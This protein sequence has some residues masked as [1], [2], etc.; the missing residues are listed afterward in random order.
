MKGKVFKGVAVALVLIL[1]ATVPAAA[2]SGRPVVITSETDQQLLQVILQ[3][4]ITTFVPILAGLTSTWVARQIQRVRMQMTVDQI[5]FA[6][7]LIQRFVSAAQQYDLKGIALRSGKE[8]KAWVVQRVSEELAQRK[9][10]LD[11]SLL[12]DMVEAAV[13]DGI[14]Q[15]AEEAARS[16]AGFALPATQ[17]AN[18]ES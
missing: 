7:T 6:D 8:K 14:N 9:I 3:V 4:L 2:F 5:A 10:T 18:E 12:A 16:Q 17:T 13:Y 15:Q 1:A 11:V